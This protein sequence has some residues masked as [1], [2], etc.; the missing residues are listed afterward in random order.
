M[1]AAWDVTTISPTADAAIR[2]KYA[3]TVL[4]TRA[5]APRGGAANPEHCA[6]CLEDGDGVIWVRYCT[7][8]ASGAV[9]EVTA[10]AAKKS[11]LDLKEPVGSW[12]LM[13]D[14]IFIPW[15]DTI[16]KD[17]SITLPS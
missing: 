3:G 2:G 14:A 15:V 4:G 8:N 16:L 11:E 10:G 5:V 12:P 7:V 13:G 6:I 1:D 17:W 9:E